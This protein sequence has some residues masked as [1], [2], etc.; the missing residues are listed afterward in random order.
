MIETRSKIGTVAGHSAGQGQSVL[1]ICNYDRFQRPLKQE[2]DS[3]R[4]ENGTTAGQQRDKEEEGN[5]V[6]PLANANGEA[7]FWAGARAYL[8][9]HV[10]GDPGSLIGKWLRQ[11][12]KEMT[13]AAINAAQLEKALSPVAYIE[14]YFRRHSVRAQPTVPL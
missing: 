8:A 3:E 13:V 10:K 14:G 11:H 4:A 7:A 6:I 1:T 5:N 9:P 12:R 2:R